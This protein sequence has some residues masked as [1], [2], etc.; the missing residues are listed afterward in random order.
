MGDNKTVR[1]YHYHH[2][3]HTE[4]AEEENLPDGTTEGTAL[5]KNGQI[6]VKLVKFTLNKVTFFKHGQKSRKLGVA[7]VKRGRHNWENVKF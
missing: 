4:G 7:Q 6:Y 2:Q 5:R 1:N 3:W